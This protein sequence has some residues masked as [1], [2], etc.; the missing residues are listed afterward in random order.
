MTVYNI[1]QRE[2]LDE[3]KTLVASDV[4]DRNYSVSGLTKG[5]K[6]LF[7]V[8]AVKSG[9]EKIS[10]ESLM[11]FGKAWTPLEIDPA[12]FLLSDYAVT[13]T[14]NRVG[15]LTDQT[16]NAY[17]FTQSNN[18]FKPVL[19]D[20]K[21]KFDGVDDRLNI[22]TSQ[23]DIYRSKSNAYLFFVIEPLSASSN[24]R[25]VF[26]TIT[27]LATRIGLHQINSTQMRFSLRSVESDTLQSIIFNYSANEKMILFCEAD[28]VAKEAKV[29]KNGALVG[30]I[31]MTTS[32]NTFT[33]VT[34]SL[35]PQLGDG[36]GGVQAWHGDLMSFATGTN[37]VLDADRQKLEGWAA[38]KYGLTDNLPIDH[39]YKIL[40]PT[41]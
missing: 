10:D 17:N 13:D 26:I 28:L 24:A 8:G 14:A 34:P 23:A 40:V 22:T 30:S 12:S 39:P 4:L 1:Y 29:F 20:Q 37:K 19:L 38:H 25:P 31:S 18:S 15:Q 2:T 6:Y 33:N 21:V 9:I 32:S 5:K 3:P 41:I 11:L 27:G 35:Y 36:G 16:V 7:S